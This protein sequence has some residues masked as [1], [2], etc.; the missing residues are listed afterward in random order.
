VKAA[1]IVHVYF[2]DF[3]GVA[4]STLKR[5]GAFDISLVSD[6]PVFIDPFLLFGSRRPIYKSLHAKIIDYL[7]FLRSEADS[8]SL[9]PALVGAW[10][11]FKEVHQLW[12]GF[13]QLGNRGAGL[14]SDFARHLHSSLGDIFADFGSERV[15]K[16]S[17]LEKVCL[18][19]PG[20]GRDRIS[21]FTAR[22]ILDYLCEYTQKFARTHLSR[23]QKKVCVVDRA[24]FDYRIKR[25]MPARFT[26]PYYRGDYVLLTPRDILTKDDRSCLSSG[27]KAETHHPRA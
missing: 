15:T 16:T 22:L 11:A 6:L 25:W 27:G 21:D 12:L 8:G 20:V 4:P 17:H 23:R 26:L 13:T 19:R 24:R 14:G 2:T 3:F 9:D 5:Y 1:P 10:Y 7:R 18:I